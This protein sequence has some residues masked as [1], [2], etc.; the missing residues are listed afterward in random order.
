MEKFSSFL[1]LKNNFQENLAKNSFAPKILG[2]LHNFIFVCFFLWNQGTKLSNRYSKFLKNR[3]FENFHFENQ[4][5]HTAWS[6]SW[7]NNSNYFISNLNSMP[8]S[9]DSIKF[10]ASIQRPT[11]H[12]LTN[13]NINFPTNNP[14]KGKTNKLTEKIVKVFSQLHFHKTHAWNYQ[15]KNQILT[16]KVLQ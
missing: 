13:L 9:P 8:F 2:N 7:K 15:K 3:I 11:E 14:I 6:D 10:S 5:K 4:T 1:L 16:E 12:L